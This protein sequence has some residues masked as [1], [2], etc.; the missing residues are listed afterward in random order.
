MTLNREPEKRSGSQ[1]A[2]PAR[3]QGAEVDEVLIA[4]ARRGDREAFTELV[5]IYT[6]LLTGFLASKMKDREAVADVVQETWIK[7]FHHLDRL[8]E[9]SRFPSWL[10]AIASRAQVDYHRAPPTRPMP[11]VNDTNPEKIDPRPLP[12]TLSIR[13]EESNLILESLGN[14]SPKY[15]TVLRLSLLHGLT[16]IEIAD[17]LELRES[18]VRMRLKRGLAKVRKSLESK[19]LS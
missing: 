7:A 14:L 10:L 13:N 12:D 9:L 16:S 3:R 8:R 2:T 5:R 15:Q 1:S 4:R 19:G 11:L 17:V 18:T 6:P